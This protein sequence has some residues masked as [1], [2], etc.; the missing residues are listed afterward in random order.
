MRALFAFSF[1]VSLLTAACTSANAGAEIV[2]SPTASV[3]EQ[4]TLTAGEQTT[5]NGTSVAV[6]FDGVQGD[7]R[8]P[9][10]FACVLGGSARVNIT[11][12][13][14]SSERGYTFYT[15]DPKAVTHN[16]LSIDLVELVPFP[17]SSLEANAEPY[18]ATLRV[19]R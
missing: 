15:G 7:S 5:V 14:G 17:F 11:V 13:E 10:G 3:N 9:P 18:R 2:T 1:V 12:L 19:T 8:C 4:F 6:R 16:G